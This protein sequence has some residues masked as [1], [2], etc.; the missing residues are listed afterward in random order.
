MERFVKHPALVIAT[1][2]AALLAATWYGLP[3]LLKPPLIA[4]NRATAGLQEKTVSTP[5]HRIHYLEGGEGP[6]VLLLHG[7][8][9]EKDH[10]VDFARALPGKYRLIVPD[11]PGFGASGRHDSQTYD[12]DTQVRHLLDFMNALGLTQA[13]L[14]GNSMGGTIAALFAIQHPGRAASVAFIGSPHG[15]RTPRPSEMDRLIDAG[16]SP[17]VARDRTEF[18]AMM[19][20]VFAQPPFLPYP[21]L[22]SAEQDAIRMAGSNRRLW[23]A[24]QK[25]GYLLDARIAE[26]KQPAFALWGTA[27]RVFDVSGA[28]VLRQRLP[29]ARIVTLPGVGHLPMMEKPRGQCCRLRRLSGTAASSAR[30]GPRAVGPSPVPQRASWWP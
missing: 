22:K 25:D 3:S 4:A 30:T 2:L 5:T 13:H 18:D 23:N 28:D 8:F 17:L 7:I 15:L 9:A 27:D 20:L 11:L 12:Y 6:V 24:Q 29:R 19:T 26:L 14:A 10:W 16:R 21:I 1:I